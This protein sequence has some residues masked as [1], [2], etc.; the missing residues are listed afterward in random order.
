M[1]HPPSSPAIVAILAGG[2]ATRFDGQDKGTI[3]L[4]G[5]RFIDI[6]LQRLSAQADEIII[7]GTY[8]YDL[9]IEIIPDAQDAP[10]GPVGGIYSIWKKLSSRDV[11]GF[12]TVPVD[13]PSLPFDL[14]KRLYSPMSSSVAADEKRRHPTY[15]WWRMT[16]LSHLFDDINIQHSISLNKLADHMSAKDVHWT[17]ENN[18]ININRPEDLRIVKRD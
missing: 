8:D 1:K 7:S 18:F 5:K 16:E 12:F 9:G 2:K 15:G 3:K 10:G 13:G 11:E 6:I 17:G 4:G 14:T